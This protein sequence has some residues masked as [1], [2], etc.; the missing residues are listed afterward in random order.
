[1]YVCRYVCRYMQICVFMHVRVCVYVGVCVC[2]CVCVYMHAFA[3]HGDENLQ[4]QLLRRL[5][6]EQ[7]MLEASM[8]YIQTK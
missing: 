7:P 5:R 4:S 2:V 6:Q 3:G 8:G 1:V